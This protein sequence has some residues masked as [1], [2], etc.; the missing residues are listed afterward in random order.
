MLSHFF[1]YKV[2][3]FELFPTIAFLTRIEMVVGINNCGKVTI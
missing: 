1:H 2:L 3:S